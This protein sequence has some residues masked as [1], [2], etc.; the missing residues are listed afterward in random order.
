MD[1]AGVGVVPGTPGGLFLR[2][3]ANILAVGPRP[4]LLAAVALAP[5]PLSRQRIQG[6]GNA[7][8]AA[9]RPIN[10]C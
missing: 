4:A 9:S 6:A 7:N 8:L 3:E 5:H 10:A 1:M 2:L